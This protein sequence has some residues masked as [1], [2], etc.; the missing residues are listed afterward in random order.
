MTDLLK[1][2]GIKPDLSPEETLEQLREKNLEYLERIQSC[3]D[4][5]R[6]KE[7]LNCKHKLRK[8][9]TACLWESRLLQMQ[10]LV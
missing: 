9:L 2:L 8:P 1:K 3:Q 10:R 4:D 7:L 6:K 5:A